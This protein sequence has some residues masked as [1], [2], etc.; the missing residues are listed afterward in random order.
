MR[1]TL[2]CLLVTALACGGKDAVEGQPAQV[3]LERFQLLRFLQGN[4]R[5]TGGGDEPFYESYLFVDDSTIRTFTYA[6]STFAQA[7][8]SGLVQWRAGEVAVE[9]GNARWMAVSFDSTAMEFSPQRGATNLFR[10]TP[11]TRDRW[12]AEL[13]WP[14]PSGRSRAYLMERVGS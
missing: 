1:R 4:W 2:L 9:G 5:G 8:D 11:E 13:A 12:A 14:G 10:W 6:D 7:R 3:S